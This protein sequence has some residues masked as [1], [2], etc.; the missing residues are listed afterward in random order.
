MTL[1][2]GSR[3]SKANHLLR[4]SYWFTCVSSVKIWPLVQKIECRQGFFSQRNM[5]L[6]TLKFRSRSPILIISQGP[7][8]DAWMKTKLFH[9]YTVLVTLTIRSRLPKSQVRVQTRFFH[10]YM[11][12]VTLKIRSRSSKSDNVLR[13]SQW[14]ICAAALVKIWRLVQKIECRQGFFTELYDP[15][16]P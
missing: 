13:A 16:W 6:V 2:F 7:P 10:G 1:K 3:S 14:C 5:I 15:R 8:N 9:S 12:L 11:T 4:S